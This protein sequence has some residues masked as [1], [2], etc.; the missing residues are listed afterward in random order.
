MHKYSLCFCLLQVV[1]RCI[2]RFSQI[3]QGKCVKVSL[4]H[5]DTH[6]HTL[7]A[8]AK[9]FFCTGLSKGLMVPTDDNKTNL[10]T[11]QQEKPPTIKH[12]WIMCCNGFVI[13]IVFI[14]EVNGG[15]TASNSK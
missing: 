6:T 4:T 5:S 10:T 9:F 12:G 15:K 3:H 2:F 8:E 13:K 1:L 7:F 14:M 11:S